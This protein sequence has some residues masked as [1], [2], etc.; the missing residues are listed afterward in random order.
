M[1]RVLRPGGIV[2]VASVEYD[3]LILAGPHENLLR[4]FY[5]IREQL[6]IRDGADPYLGRRLRG[7]LTEG[8][9]IDV[10]ATTKAISYGTSELVATFGRGRAEDCEDDWY[11]SSAVDA[12]LATSSE[13][14]AMHDAWLAWAE[15]PSAYAAF[16]WCRALGRKS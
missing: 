16:T 9:F 11:A 15:A 3:G 14:E 4:R 12:G 10:E 1:R 13:V 5:A 2:A 7:L 6:W 8:A